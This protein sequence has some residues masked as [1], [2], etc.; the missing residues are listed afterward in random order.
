MRAASFVAAV[1]GCALAA[2]LWF[3]VTHQHA[4]AGRPSAGPALSWQ[5]PASGGGQHQHVLPH[6]GGHRSGRGQQQNRNDNQQ[7]Q[8]GPDRGSL[9][10]DLPRF[11]D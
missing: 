10:R 3:G 5:G 4:P 8:A 7:Q 11:G 1:A 9:I 2:L 6:S